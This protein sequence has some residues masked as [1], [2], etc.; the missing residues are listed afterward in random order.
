MSKIQPI[1]PDDVTLEIPDFVIKIVND[2]IQK[3]MGRERGIFQ[4]V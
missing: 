4:S 1:R 3:K 2:L